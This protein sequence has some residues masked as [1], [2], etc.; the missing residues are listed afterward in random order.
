MNSKI[1]AVA[2]SILLIATACKKNQRDLVQNDG[3]L[4][5]TNP[6]NCNTCGQTKTK[7]EFAADTIINGTLTLCPDKTYILKGKMWINNGGKIV[8]PKGTVIKGRK[9]A[10][11]AAAS[12]LVVTKGGQIESS[13]DSTCPVIFTSESDSVGGTPAPGDWGGVV[14]LGKSIVNTG[15][16]NFIE[17]INSAPATIDYT[18]G[19]TDS[20]DNSGWL[21]Y[22][23]IQYAGAIVS[24]DNELNGLTCGG[25]GCGTILDHVQVIFGADDGFEFFGGTVNGKYLLSVSNND[26]QFDFDLGYRGNLQYIV[27]ILENKSAVTGFYANNNTNGIESDN[28]PATANPKNRFPFT[29]PV[30]SNMTIAGPANC[31][32][33]NPVILNAFRFRNW[34]RFVVRN[35]VIYNFPTGARVETGAD[36]MATRKLNPGCDSNID[37]SYFTNNVIYGCTNTFTGWIV[38]PTGQAATGNTAALLGIRNPN[39]YSSFFLPNLPTGRGLEPNASPAQGGTSFCGL[40]PTNCGFTY[41][42]SPANKGGAVDANGRYWLADAW[43]A[44][45]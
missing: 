31:T 14:I 3:G 24:T 2:C 34:S 22:T 39:S 25:V 17:G 12:A 8:I 40:T 43:V 7:V 13:G 15:T 37:S 16:G 5:H 1:L 27:A 6:T 29:R 32:A 30:I 23:R 44:S 20:T 4:A 9:N 11:A 41:S 28:A 10:T 36:T 18:Y 45:N 33:Q 21:K 38:T 19:G 26:D 42:T 35:S